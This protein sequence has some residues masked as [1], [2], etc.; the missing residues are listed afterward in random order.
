MR[1]IKIKMNR[2]CDSSDNVIDIDS[3]LFIDNDGEN[4]MK[5]EEVYD[6]LMVFPDIAVVDRDPYPNLVPV[7]SVYGEKYVR[8][9]PDE[10]KR[11]NLLSLPRE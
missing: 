3:I 1:A 10:Y 8:S 11:D 4:W 7:K 9:E 2:G 5:K 6:L